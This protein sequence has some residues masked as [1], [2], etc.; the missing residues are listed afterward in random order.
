MNALE[1]IS[2]NGTQQWVLVRSEK[3]DAPLL[4]HVQ[5]GPG[6]PMIPEAD[7]LEQQTHLEQDY[8]VA[9]WDQRGCGKSYQKAIDP[10][11][12]NFRQLTDDM[13]ACTR[14]L[15]KKYNRQKATLVGYSI[16]ATI[17]LMAAAK[18]SRL[19]EQLFLV[20]VDID[21]PTAND[22]A[23]NFASENARESGNRNWMKQVAEL[24]LKT[25]V[26]AKTFQ[27]RTKL[28]TNL[29]GIHT[30]A[31][32]QQLLFATIGNMLRSRAYKLS[33]IP[34]TIRGMEFCQ[35]ALLRE[36]NTLN[37]FDTVQK[38]AVPVHFVQGKKDAVAPIQTAIDYYKH[39]QAP[40]KSFTVFEQSAHMPH[41]EEP[42]KFSALIK[43]GIPAKSL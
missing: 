25:I 31:K 7:S 36:L 14:Y 37:L 41:Y 32:Y 6:F 1:R 24:R 11:T 30:K 27:I 40:E 4:I 43:Y 19:F 22:H 2:I 12:I 16:G 5:A 26:D 10:A 3:E 9:Y 34:R 39:L 42:D 29:G 8:L 21:L 38:I 18:E 13:I 17:S 35:N 20:G 23:L 15:L 28:L 33:D